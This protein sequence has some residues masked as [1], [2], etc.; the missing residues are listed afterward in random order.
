MPKPPQP[1]GA[2]FVL[3][4]RKTAVSEAGSGNAV[5]SFRRD[6]KIGLEEE[7]V[8]HNQQTTVLAGKE[9]TEIPAA[10]AETGIE[11]P[12]ARSVSVIFANR[13]SP[14]SAPSGPFEFR[15]EVR[16]WKAGPESRPGMGRL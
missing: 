10:A 5:C 13:S 14:R 8:I 3:V 7:P 1:T 2:I 9:I 6:L 12:L 15:T 4:T 16:R 11:R